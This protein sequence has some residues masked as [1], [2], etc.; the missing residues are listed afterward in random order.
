MIN[1][2]SEK[3]IGVQRIRPGPSDP[4]FVPRPLSDPNLSAMAQDPDQRPDSDEPAS[5]STPG[6]GR[7]DPKD[8]AA[9]M[10]AN[11]RASEALGME[12]V[13]VGHGRAVVRMVVRPDMVNGLNVCH[14]GLIFSLA[15]SA[16]AFSSN[17]SNRYAIATNAEVDWVN[18]GRLGATLTATAVEQYQRGR[19]AV[20]DAV[21]TDETGETIALFRGRTRLI[22]GQHLP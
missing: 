16:M 8:V 13:E 10:Y 22:D 11:D 19:S 14:G 15:D 7:H 5:E 9:A 12:I 3:R 17:S 2:E 20:T 18:P 1:R 4:N 6:Y 21:V